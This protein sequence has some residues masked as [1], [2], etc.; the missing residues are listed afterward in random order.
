MA[1]CGWLVAVSLVLSVATVHSQVQLAIS[2]VGVEKGLVV[3]VAGGLHCRT[4]G[5]VRVG[6]LGGDRRRPCCWH[7]Q[8]SDQA[9]DVL[10]GGG[11]EEL[12]LNELQPTQTETL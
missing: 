9:F 7:A 4:F 2:G 6:R 10:G 8:E 3:D 11:Q 5:G 1:C 12:F